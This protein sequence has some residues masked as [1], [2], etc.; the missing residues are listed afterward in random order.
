MS[1]SPRTT[2]AQPH[3]CRRGDRGV[4]TGLTTGRRRPAIL[5]VGRAGDDVDVDRPGQT[6]DTIDDRA[7]EQLAP[8]RAAG[9]PEHDLRRVLR[10]GQVDERAGDVVARDPSVLA[11]Q[12]LDQP[13]LGGD[14]LLRRLVAGGQAGIG[15]HVDADQLALGPLRDPRGPADEVIGPRRARQG[16]DHPLARLPRPGDAVTVAVLGER[17]VD[18]IGDPEESQLSQRR[19]V[20]GT[21]VVPERHV[22]LVGAVD[23]AVGESPPQGLGCHVDELDLI[24]GANRV[25]RHR[26]PLAD[27]GDPLDDVVERLE[28]LDVDRRD[29]VDSGGEDVLHVLPALVVPRSRGVRVGELVDEHEVGHGGAGWRRR[30]S[31]R[32]RSPGVR[33]SAAGSPRGHR[34]A[35]RCAPDRGSRRTRRRRRRPVRGADDLR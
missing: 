29:D 28:V 18:P 11:A 6:D 30:P 4:S 14:P 5:P 32:S 9:R 17:V 34:S 24:G 27:A 3:A 26:L 13:A 10:P 21:E 8:S 2:S 15:D 25:I 23:V 35:R 1:G 7:A 31:R 19:E 22:D 20:A 12:F 33:P 16:D